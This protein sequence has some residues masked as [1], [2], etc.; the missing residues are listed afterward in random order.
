[1]IESAKEKIPSKHKWELSAV[2]PLIPIV[3]VNHRLPIL[4]ISNR[5]IYIYSTEKTVHQFSIGYMINPSIHIN[6]IFKTKIE[7]L[8]GCY[9][10]IE[11][12]QTIKKFQRRRIHLLWH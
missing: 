5:M 6:K 11:T 3:G 8:L 10:F 7:K 12:M 1:M 2:I 4:H 9:F